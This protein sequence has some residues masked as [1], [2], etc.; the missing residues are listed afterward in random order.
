[1][2]EQT[3]Q[4]VSNERDTDQYFRLVV[5][6][7]Q[8]APLRKLEADVLNFG[9]SGY[10]P[11]Q[12]LL[13][14]RQIW[15]FLIAKFLT[16]P[17]WWFYLYWLPSYLERE[18]GQNPLKSAGL[19]AIIYTG[20]SIGSIVGA[21]SI[22]VNGRQVISPLQGF[23]QLWQKTYTISLAGAQVTPQQVVQ[24]WKEKFGSFWPKGNK[25][26][27]AGSKVAVNQ[28]AVLNLAGPGGIQAPG[29]RSLV[30]TG[31]LVIYEDDESFSFI[32]PD[33]HIFAG[34]NTFSALPRSVC[35]NSGSVMSWRTWSSSKRRHNSSA[36]RTVTAVGAAKWLTEKMALLGFCASIDRCPDRLRRSDVFEATIP[37]ILHRFGADLDPAV[38]QV[39]HRRGQDRLF[40]GILQGFGQAAAQRSDQRI[41]GTQVDPYRQAAL[42]GLRAL[43][44]FSD[45][46]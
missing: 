20:A 36:K 15:P 40:V 3:V 23:G 14:Y 13:R 22:N 21:V 17:V 38:G 30:S 39:A 46:Q 29:G 26:Y 31:I 8:I 5:R 43:S 42:V 37:A 18:R 28:V 2:L 10:G 1:M 9:V 25:I 45:L 41:G 19:L 35:V 32:T 44:G 7:P 27:T 12:A 6:T 33:G 34:M 4:I 11:D 16:D 24:T